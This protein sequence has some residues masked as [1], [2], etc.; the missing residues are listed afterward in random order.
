VSVS[1]IVAA[2][3][4]FASMLLSQQI[5]I[6]SAARLDDK[7]KLRIAEVFPRRNANYTMIVFGMIIVFLI[8]LYLFP[9][10]SL[11]VS[12]FYAVSFGIYIVAK[13][14]LNVRKLREIDAPGDYIRSI[15]LSFGVFI[16]GIVLSLLAVM[17]VEQFSQSKF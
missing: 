6:R 10:S 11:I 15:K 3:V 7:T 16:G 14:V 12:I 17:M 2:A 1:L 13:L 8:A 4:F 5:G 9:N